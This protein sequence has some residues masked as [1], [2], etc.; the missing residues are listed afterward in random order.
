MGYRDGAVG[1]PALIVQRLEYLRSARDAIH[2]PILELRESPE[3]E[4]RS[5]A[6]SMRFPRT[7]ATDATSPSRLKMIEDTSLDVRLASVITFDAG[8]SFPYPASLA[9][10]VQRYILGGVMSTNRWEN[11]AAVVLARGLR[12]T[13]ARLD[14]TTWAKEQLVPLGADESRR[15]TVLLVLAALLPPAAADPIVAE[16]TASGWPSVQPPLPIDPATLL[17]IA[18]SMDRNASAALARLIAAGPDEAAMVLS[19]MGSTDPRDDPLRVTATKLFGELSDEELDG[20]LATALKDTG[21]P[22]ER[23]AR[24]LMR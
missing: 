9:P 7:R 13:H 12:A 6:A 17:R 5:T 14:M 18:R 15:R 3:P 1:N 4:L 2:I 10:E 21:S 23:V 8:A 20:R 22:A 16:L 11:H 24:S 19:A